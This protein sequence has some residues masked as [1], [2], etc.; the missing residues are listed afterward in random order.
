MSADVIELSTSAEQPETAVSAIA[1][2]EPTVVEP[3]VPDAPRDEVERIEPQPTGPVK[4]I[5]G[6][7]VDIVPMKL[8]ET[9]RLLRIV[10]RGAGGAL[11]STVADLDLN[12]PARFAQTFGALILFSIPEAE[13]E[14][15]DFIQSMVLP[16]GYDSMNQ[17]QRIDALN[18]LAVE[19]S[20]PELE[21]TVS[22]VE[23]V[24]RRESED[25][26][27]LGKRI[28]QAFQLTRKVT[29]DLPAAN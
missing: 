27:N 17:E 13:N 20:N 11:E 18:K 16:V 14:A 24:V 21:D 23:R 4:L 3:V 12:D 1:V 6:L 25:I 26:R 8:R 7:E 5:S 2:S 10:T 15:V 28:T 9:M 29:K 22:I 19:L